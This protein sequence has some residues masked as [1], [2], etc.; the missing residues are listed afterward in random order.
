ME[1]VSGAPDGPASALIAELRALI[2][3]GGV[4]E[5]DPAELARTG[6]SGWTT[7][8]LTAA[9]EALTAEGAVTRAEKHLCP[10]QACRRPISQEDIAARR[11]PHCMTDFRTLDDPQSIVRTV[12]RHGGPLSRD[13]E[14]AVVVHGMNT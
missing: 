11:C 1:R 6:K 4:P 5:L 10:V 12:Y 3:D 8:R 13:L 2:A 7:G 9:L 14:W